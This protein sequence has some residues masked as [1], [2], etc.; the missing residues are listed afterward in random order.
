MDEHLM[1]A[2]CPPAAGSVGRGATDSPYK[3][4]KDGGL[5]NV[6]PH[7]ILVELIAAG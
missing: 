4:A 1:N 6:S 5:S 7:G 3:R 2:H